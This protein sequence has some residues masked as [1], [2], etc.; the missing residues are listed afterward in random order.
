MSEMNAALPS[1]AARNDPKLGIGLGLVSTVLLSVMWSLAKVLSARYPVE[2]IS[3]FRC[4]LAFVP[5]GAMIAAQGGLPLLRT[6]RLAGHVWRSVIGVTSMVLGFISY[7]LMP[8]ADA[9]SISFTAPLLVTALSVPLLGEK[10]GL[11]RWG[12]VI[13]GFLG[14]LLII[15]PRRPG[16]SWRRRLYGAGHGD[17]PPTE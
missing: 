3:F 5:A 13:V 11:A 14:V 2:E 6:H 8:L 15:Q 12:A 17:D 9:V 1:L 4:A 7:H 10:V 16:G